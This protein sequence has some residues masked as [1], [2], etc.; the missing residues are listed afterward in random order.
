MKEQGE[1]SVSEGPGHDQGV[2][3]RFANGWDCAQ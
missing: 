1:R 3:L 2:E